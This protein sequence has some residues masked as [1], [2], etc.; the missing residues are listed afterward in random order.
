MNSKSLI[1]FGDKKLYLVCLL[2]NND[3]TI[4]LK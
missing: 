1:W 2:D 3:F 4:N